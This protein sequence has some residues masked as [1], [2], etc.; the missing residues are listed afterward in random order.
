MKAKAGAG[1][2]PGDTPRKKAPTRKPPA[3]RV[4]AKAKKAA[5]KARPT[6]RAPEPRTTTAAKESGRTAKPIS[7][8]LMPRERAELDEFTALTDIGPTVLY[9][10]L[11]A[12]KLRAALW[13]IKSMN[14]AGM[15]IRSADLAATVWFPESSSSDLDDLYSGAKAVGMP[16]E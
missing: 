6:R 13:A 12:P 4:V 11:V 14:E 7:M 8:S 16:D 2:T 3:R 10:E 5:P 1:S 9:R 15:S